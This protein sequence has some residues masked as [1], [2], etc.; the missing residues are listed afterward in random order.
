M[1]KN[2]KHNQEDTY[3]ELRKGLTHE[4]LKTGFQK[5]FEKDFD[6]VLKSSFGEKFPNRPNVEDYDHLYKSVAS[7]GLRKRSIHKEMS[8][9]FRIPYEQVLE[10]AKKSEEL[11]LSK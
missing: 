7:F 2:I 8:K 3:E 6:K 4:E 5:K 11:K 9:K 1:D 10:L